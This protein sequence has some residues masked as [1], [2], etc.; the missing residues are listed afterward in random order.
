MKLPRHQQAEDGVGRHHLGG[1][2]EKVVEVVL[3]R[4]G[5]YG[6]GYVWKC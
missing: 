2:A 1:T 3:G 4:R 5:G 6:S